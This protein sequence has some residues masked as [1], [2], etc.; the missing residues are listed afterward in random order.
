MTTLS[1]PSNAVSALIKQWNSDDQI[2]PNIAA[3]RT[4]P[5]RKAKLV[6]LPSDLSP[7]ISGLLK[8]RGIL[9]LYTHQQSSW[10][11]I[12]AGHNIVVVTSTA[13]GKT[14]CYSLPIINQLERDPESRSLILYPTKALAYD[15][16]ASFI[17]QFATQEGHGRDRSAKGL[18]IAAYD[19]DSQP[20]NVV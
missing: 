14:L 10:Q 20:A 8:G 2:S 3:W 12:Q 13:S 1:S 11:Q 19:G 4:L 6:P 16:V 18:A 15:Q 7:R 9:G 5:A 17:E